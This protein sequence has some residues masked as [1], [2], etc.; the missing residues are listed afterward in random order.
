MVKPVIPNSKYIKLIIWKGFRRKQPGL[1]CAR[2]I[3]FTVT[4]LLDV[5]CTLFNLLKPVGYVMHQQFSIQQQYALPTL[6]LCVLYI[7]ENKQ[8]LVPLTA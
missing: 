4:Y 1:I 2:A 7:S 3:T 8:G 5:I 6:Y